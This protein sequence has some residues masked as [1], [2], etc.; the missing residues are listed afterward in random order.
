M[1]VKSI[2]TA[3]ISNARTRQ[4]NSKNNNKPTIQ[5]SFQGGFNPV[6]TLMDAIDRGGFAASFIAQDGIG[7]VYPR[8]KEGLNRGREIDENGKKHGSLNWEFAR[9]EGIR[10]ILSGPSAFIIPF[11][12]M[13]GIKKYSGTANNVSIDMIKGLGKNFEEFAQTSPDAIK[14]TAEAKKLF[15]NQVFENVL[16]TSTQEIQPDKTVKNTLSDAKI[17]E[18]ASSFT[19]KTIEIENAKS[20]GFVRNL[21]GKTVSGSKEDLTQ[22]L[23]DEFMLLR[24]QNLSPSVNEMSASLKVPGRENPIGES[25]KKMLGSIKDF[26]DDAIS[27]TQKKLAKAPDTNISEFIQKFVS[28]RS[29]SRFVS[30]MSMFLAVVGFYTL[31]PK[32]YNMGLKENPALKQQNQ[33]V[34]AAP[35]AQGITEKATDTPANG[36]KDVAFQGAGLQKALSKTGDAVSNSSWLKKLSDN[37]EFNGPSMPVPAMLTLLF[38]F[39]LPPR[40]IQAQDSYD[41]REILV[42]DVSSF[43]A[44]LFAAEALKRGCSN[45]FSKVTGLALNTKP[46]D[47]DKSVLHKFKNYF[48]PGEGINVL[49]S[50][51]IVSKYSDIESYKGGINGFFDFIENNGGNIKK[52]LRLDKTVKANAEAIVGKP[53]KQ[54]TADE[55]K[56][57]FKNVKNQNALKNIYNAFKNKDNKY[58]KI[59]KTANSSFGFVSTLVLVPLFMMH[60]AR[61]C[62]RMTKKSIAKAEA[63]KSAQN[64]LTAETTPTTGQNLN[65]ISS[66]K[67]TMAGFLNK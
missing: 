3:E 65:Y 61:F 2:S 41:R 22:A 39:C 37:F 46:Q 63:E 67:P 60:L 54:A 8:I 64:S 38:G 28:R 51:A 45:V 58:I 19:E 25:F 53:L 52:V 18:L 40:Y 27:S 26:S 42:R 43:T 9:K 48:T 66:Q 10:E 36:K 6:V 1:V 11:F 4:Q 7:M 23:T 57:A 33:G 13:Q 47:H 34:Q 49:K 32:L 14:N 20:K 56:N 59:A 55:I 12:I 16:R 44:I 5:P 50:E 24:K 31:I 30:N 29:G 21:I 15:Y 35:A 17:K 62:D